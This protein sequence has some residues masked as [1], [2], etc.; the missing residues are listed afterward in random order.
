MA[1][2]CGVDFLLEGGV[3]ENE[4]SMIGSRY[5]GQGNFCAHKAAKSMYTDLSRAQA[6]ETASHLSSPVH[7]GYSLDAIPTHAR[8]RTTLVG[9]L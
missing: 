7:L 8:Q 4:V 5:E 3:D 6:G 9:T 2:D 1:D